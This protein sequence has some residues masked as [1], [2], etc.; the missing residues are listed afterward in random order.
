MNASTRSIVYIVTA[1]VAFA[2][3]TATIYAGVLDPTKL[4]EAVKEAGAVATA[5][6]GIFSGVLARLNLTPDPQ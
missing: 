6:L 5:I 4:V 2:T 1:L 3:L